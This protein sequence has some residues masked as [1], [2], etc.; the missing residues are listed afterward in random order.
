M[1]IKQHAEK[2][3]KRVQYF[4]KRLKQNLSL[5]ALG[6][7][8]FLI[9]QSFAPGC[10]PKRATLSKPGKYNSVKTVNIEGKED[11]NYKNIK[12]SV[13]INSIKEKYKENYRDPQRALYLTA[14]K[15]IREDI[16]YYPVNENK[17]AIIEE[18]LNSSVITDS[19]EIRKNFNKYSVIWETGIVPGT[20]MDSL[21]TRIKRGIEITCDYHEIRQNPFLGI[22]EFADIFARYPDVTVTKPPEHRAIFKLSQIDRESKKGGK[23]DGKKIEEITIMEL[24][25]GG[26]IINL[27]QDPYTFSWK[28]TGK[29]SNDP[30]KVREESAEGIC[31]FFE[32]ILPP[33]TPQER[34]ALTDVMRQKLETLADG[35]IYVE[36]R[37]RL[38]DD[39]GIQQ[40]I[41]PCPCD[42][43][44][45]SQDYN[46]VDWNCL[47]NINDI[48]GKYSKI[49]YNDSINCRVEL[50][51]CDYYGNE[52]LNSCN[53]IRGSLTK[54]M[55]LNGEFWWR[56]I[57][58]IFANLD[59]TDLK[60][61]SVGVRLT[62]NYTNEVA[63]RII[64]YNFPE[65]N[66]VP[67][68]R[69]QIA[70][71]PP[72]EAYLPPFVVDGFKIKKIP[73]ST[74]GFL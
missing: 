51:I 1:K 61:V 11:L 48:F 70:A 74:Y 31:S 54:P 41:Y 15:L 37:N 23:G 68:Y 62:N 33:P 63:R 50:K 73:A 18:I 71:G 42:M 25:Y 27:I 60:E 45:N 22:G 36:N 52:I 34:F 55:D 69:G 28:V 2:A 8:G 67:N 26:K 57:S 39:V 35:M 19:L 4:R 32:D 20:F 44:G 21:E 17:F 59:S 66:K 12:H 16:E 24:K 53:D 40:V 14:L 56:T 38:L 7:A 29:E 13:F 72:N 58:K 46:R 64:N 3:V 5:K 47:A 30:E 43:P 65:P 9:F 6:L 10:L 49:V